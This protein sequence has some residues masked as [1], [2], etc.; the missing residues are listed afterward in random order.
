[1]S[2]ETAPQ[3]VAAVADSTP[4]APAN[5]PSAQPTA[6]PARQAIIEKY[7]KQF[8]PPP[9]PTPEPVATEPPATPATPAPTPD[10]R[11]AQLAA[12]AA[13]LQEL[14]ASIP[15]PPPATSTSTTP[16]AET[17]DWLS[18]LATGDKDKG[19]EALAALM[20]N[21]IGKELIAAAVEQANQRVNL[22]R[23]ITNF[24]AEIRTTH[25][26]VLQMEQYIT[27]GVN[28]R[29]QQWMQKN[30]NPSPVDYVKV[31][32]ES[33]NAEVENARNLIQTFRGAGKQEAITRTTVLTSTPVLAPT[34][35][36]TS[37]EQ[38][39]PQEPAAET[40][41]EYLAKRAAQKAAAQGM[42]VA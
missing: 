7:E 4:V 40:P 2:E 26:E 14:K 3:V 39:T 37:R 24:N 8:A 30:P 36:N 11:D 9:A 22:E 27:F 29:L 33:V 31:Y 19:E 17:P 23:E 28:N 15:Q 1:M 25:P 10:P 42:S 18:L 12:L 38:P 32:K 35:V 34:P 13:Q 16:A 20:K 41:M 5:A 6:D 21:K